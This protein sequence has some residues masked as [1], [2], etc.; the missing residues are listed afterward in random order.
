MSQ[1]GEKLANQGKVAKGRKVGE[2]TNTSEGLP[3][4]VANT[5]NAMGEGGDAV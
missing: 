3:K 2:G 5:R 4:P 1:K